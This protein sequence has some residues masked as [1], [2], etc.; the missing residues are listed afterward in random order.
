[1]ETEGERGVNDGIE[2]IFEEFEVIG[3][4]FLDI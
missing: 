2:G 1:M 4:C 3:F